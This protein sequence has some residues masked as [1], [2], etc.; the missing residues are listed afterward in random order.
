MGKQLPKI[1]GPEV[2]SSPGVR[3]CA[4]STS[5]SPFCSPVNSFGGPSSGIQ[6]T[7]RKTP[8][9]IRPRQPVDD[10]PGLTFPDPVLHD[11]KRQRPLSNSQPKPHRQTCPN[12]P[13]TYPSPL[14]QPG[15]L[16]P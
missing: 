16:K 5:T 3:N 4:S 1:M 15:A 11:P 2:I 6:Q 10:P 14:S 8:N 12:A 13:C 9:H 7:T